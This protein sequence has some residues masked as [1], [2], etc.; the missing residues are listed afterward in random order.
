MYD[1][2]S[3]MQTQLIITDWSE[4]KQRKSV[5]QKQSFHCGLSYFRLAFVL[6]PQINK[7]MYFLCVIKE[8]KCFQMLKCAFAKFGFF[9]TFGT[10]PL[11][12]FLPTG[13]FAVLTMC[14][15]S[16]FM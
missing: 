1:S 2:N 15:S 16:S 6:W 7:V 3:D 10:E 12:D 14:Q 8:E 11:S 9:P 5:Q 13:H 4:N